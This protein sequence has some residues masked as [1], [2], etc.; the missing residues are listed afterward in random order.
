[1]LLTDIQLP[2]IHTL[3]KKI[4]FISYSLAINSFTISTAWSLKAN[5]MIKSYVSVS[6]ETAVKI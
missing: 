6:K 5:V 4:S 2:N 3:R 1:M